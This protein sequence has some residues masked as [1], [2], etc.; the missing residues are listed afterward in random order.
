MLRQQPRVETG[1]DW[2]D[3]RLPEAL[4]SRG[5]PIVDGGQLFSVSD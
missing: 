4:P 2:R 5:D 3:A 1:F